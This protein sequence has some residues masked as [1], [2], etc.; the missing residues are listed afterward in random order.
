MTAQIADATAA[1][2]NSREQRRRDLER[3]S[4]RAAFADALGMTWTIA[5]WFWGIF[6]VVQIVVAFLANRYADKGIDLA[7]F[8]PYGAPQIFL[9][10]MG[11]VTGSGFL[12]VHVLSGGTRRSAV[13]GWLVA[14]P[15]LGV[16]FAV[17]NL[18]VGWIVKGAISLVGGEAESTTFYGDGE[19]ITATAALAVIGTVMYTSGLAVFAAYRRWGG[20]LGTLALLVTLAPASFMSWSFDQGRAVEVAFPGVG[21]SGLGWVGAVVAIPLAAALVYLLLRRIPVE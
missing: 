18:L 19:P 13:R 6:L 8:T 1:P 16:S 12:T 11:I 15:V 4:L 2:E 10:V 14:A 9:F 7:N 3:R 20:W 21:T 17:V 5:A